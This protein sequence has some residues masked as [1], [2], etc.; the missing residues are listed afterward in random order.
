[1]TLPCPPILASVVLGPVQFDRPGWL[2]L[3]IPALAFVVWFGRRSLAGLEGWTRWGALAA[4][5]FVVMALLSVLAEPSSR[6]R[7]EH[8]SVTLLTDASRSIPASVQEAVD[9]F[10]ETAAEQGRE[11]GDRLGV[12]TAAED[13][14]VQALPSERNTSVERRYTGGAD[15]T[16]LASGVRLALAVSPKDAAPRIVI[17]SDGNETSGSLLEAARAAAAQGVPIDVI[18]LRYRYPSEVIVD[19][20]IVPTSAREG[21]TVNIRI[22]LTATRPTEGTLLLKINDELVD[23]DPGAPGFGARVSLVEGLN[24]H[25]ASVD[26]GESG[27]KR[28]E[29]TFEPDMR[30]GRPSG[31]EI[32][33]NNRALGV[34]FVS[35][36]GRILLVRPPTPEG[37]SEAA[38]LLRAL[39]DNRLVPRV[40]RPDTFPTELS[41]LASYDALILLNQEAG[42]YSLAQQQIIAQYVHDVGGGLIMIGGPQSFGAGGWIGSPLADAL[43]V[44]LDPPQRKDMP[45]GALV[46]I[47][48][49]IEMPQGVYYGRRT[50]EAAINV[51]AP[52]DLAGIIEFQ[53]FG[54]AGA[55]WVHPLSAVGDK[56]AIRRSIGGLAFGDM[57]SFDPSLRLALEGLR[58]ADAGQK[59]AIIISDGDPSLTPSLLRDFTAA[60]ITISTVGVN[61]HS[62]GDLATLANIAQAT[63]GRFW[64]IP[65]AQIASIPEIFVKEARIVRRSL[66]WEGDPLTPELQLT[67]SDALRGIDF[68]PPVTG[69][70]VTAD[71]E[72]LSRVLARVGKEKDPLAAEWQHGLGRVFV[73]TSDTGVRWA[74]SW[75]AQ[76]MYR[77]FWD[78]AIRWAMRPTGSNNLRIQTEDRGD[79][80]IVTVEALD[81]SGNLLGAG[82][83]SGALARP[84][85]TGTPLSLRQVGPGRWEGAFRS[86][87]PGTYVLGVNLLAPGADGAEPIRAASQAAVTRPFADEFRAL[88]DNTALLRQVAS[89]TGGRVLFEVG[90]DRGE[91]RLVGDPAQANLF[92]REGITMPVATRSIWQTLAIIAL[93]LFILDVAIRRVRLEPRAAVAYVRRIL[94]RA[95]EKAGARLDALSSARAKARSRLDQRAQ[96]APG[97]DA[98]TPTGASGSGNA[99]S[100]A[101]LAARKYEPPPGATRMPVER[102]AGSSKAP[103]GAPTPPKSTSGP[104]AE[105]DSGLSRLRAAKRRAQEEM[106]DDTPPSA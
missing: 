94:S 103:P 54:G 76:A 33:E 56:G 79:E 75:P 62:P 26:A 58:A 74:R 27:S 68:L 28:F 40:I 49:S 46:L 19:R 39:A 44:K 57:P 85:G 45:R 38:P 88:E 78:R 83:L 52:Q 17:A 34:T 42:D 86:A 82:L 32:V 15:G 50:A 10:A 106:N 20:I 60:R 24:L 69:Y 30:G 96:P 2:W 65:N 73:F 87:D 14:F 43:P 84:D 5:M 71:R 91:V 18:P 59:H 16:D 22:A 61:P 55:E 70:V 63:G 105:P 77:P 6:K 41:D 1:M 81:A 36:E 4:R 99:A 12:I 21:Q 11:Q 67:G 53:G 101:A 48:H 47:M 93:S 7:A 37:D 80:T 31:D 64:N 51:L 23:L 92:T 102:A 3:L 29:A 97:A 104:E 9:R 66:I 8:V 98:G 100:D 25:S 72:G 35:G 89:Q 95:P 13:A 90:L